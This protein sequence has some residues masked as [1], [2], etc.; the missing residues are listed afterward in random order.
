MEYHVSEV[1]V[2]NYR[3]ICHCADMSASVNPIINSGLAFGAENVNV[4]RCFFLPHALPI[5]HAAYLYYVEESFFFG[6]GVC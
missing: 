5:S 4:C 1:F 6:G 3:E 2:V